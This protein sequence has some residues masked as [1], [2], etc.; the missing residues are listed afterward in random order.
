[1]VDVLKSE[2]DLDSICV[3]LTLGLQSL[4]YV[5]AIYYVLMTLSLA[6]PLYNGDVS[7]EFGYMNRLAANVMRREHAAL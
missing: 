3:L 4:N 5:N 2:V 7:L 1:M 6:R